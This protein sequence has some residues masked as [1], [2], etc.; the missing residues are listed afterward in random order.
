MIMHFLKCKQRMLKT[1]AF[2]T[3]SLSA[4]LIR[5]YSA[6]PETDTA[7][8]AAHVSRSNNSRVGLACAHVHLG[9]AQL[10]VL[11]RRID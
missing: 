10:P 7:A 6:W 4:P 9:R 3:K 5:P 11:E 8:L 2:S 1:T